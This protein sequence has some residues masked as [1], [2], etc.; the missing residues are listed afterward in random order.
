M[1]CLLAYFCVVKISITQ[2]CY[3]SESERL[4]PLPWTPTLYKGS[5]LYYPLYYYWF[6]TLI[7]ST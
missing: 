2:Q 6:P 3:F 5:T 1:F 4:G 7:L